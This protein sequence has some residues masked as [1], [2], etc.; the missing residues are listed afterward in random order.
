MRIKRFFESI[1]DD[2]NIKILRDCFYNLIDDVDGVNVTFNIETNKNWYYVSIVPTEPELIARSIESLSSIDNAIKR[3]KYDT[4]ILSQVKIS[5]NSLELIES[6]EKF[7]LV[8][9]DYGSYIA[10]IKFKKEENEFT[11]DGDEFIWVHRE[12]IYVDR[13]E[14]SKFIQKKFEVKIKDFGGHPDVRIQTK[15]SINRLDMDI[16]FEESTLRQRNEITDYLKTLTFEVDGEEYDIFDGSQVSK[17]QNWISLDIDN[18]IY[19]YNFR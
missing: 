16:Y 4:T 19:G 3:S 2:E 13:D 17:D 5:L 6:F 9:D 11:W 7:V 1:D 18:M 15:D 10:H 8:R 14:F 12:E